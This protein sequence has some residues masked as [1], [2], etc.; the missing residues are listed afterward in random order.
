MSMVNEE[1]LSGLRNS[2]ERGISLD[3]AAQSF[4]NAGYSPAEVMEAV[5]TLSSVS[6]SASGM[7]SSQQRSLQPLS[8]PQSSRPAF[9]NPLQQQVS[10]F[11]QLNPQRPSAMN[12]EQDKKGSNKK[13]I[14]LLSIILLVLIGALIATII[15]K[16]QILNLLS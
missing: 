15:F 2:L 10:R 12:T 11:K 9:Q 16:N 1:I 5:Q 13:I 4:I 14:I 7:Q 3:Q 6:S 8:S